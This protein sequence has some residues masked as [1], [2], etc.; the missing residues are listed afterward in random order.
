[1]KFLLGRGEVKEAPFHYHFDSY[2]NVF[3][4][5]RRPGNNGLLQR[6]KGD[7][8]ERALK[9]QLESGRAELFPSTAGR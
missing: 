4:T 3:K 2:L 1:V 6:W 8:A 5:G 9:K 7:A